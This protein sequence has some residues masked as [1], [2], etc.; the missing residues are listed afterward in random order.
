[1]IVYVYIYIYVFLIISLV[2]RLDS[3]FLVAKWNNISQ[4]SSTPGDH[5]LCTAAYRRSRLELP[6]TVYWVHVK[7]SAKIHKNTK[8]YYRI[9]PKLDPV[10][11]SLF[12][13]SV[14]RTDMIRSSPSAFLLF[15]LLN[16]GW[17]P[18]KNQ[19]WDIPSEITRPILQ[20]PCNWAE[21]SPYQHPD[22][23]G[24]QHQESTNTTEL[25]IRSWGQWAHGS[26]YSAVFPFFWYST[27]I[28]QTVKDPQYMV[29]KMSPVDP[30]RNTCF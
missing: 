4:K 14:Q 28:P 22:S 20:K 10:Y 27:P 21:L 5:L 7:Y 2:F 13:I 26:S 16:P 30:I 6:Q 15:F 1:M 11:S 8:R 3:P 23:L 25:K 19:K 17:N 18:R 29:P 9:F 12:R 24:F